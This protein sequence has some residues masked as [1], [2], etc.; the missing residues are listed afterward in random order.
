MA[1][2]GWMDRWI[3][4]DREMEEVK[5]EKQNDGETGYNILVVVTA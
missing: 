4:R 2:F 1:A 5:E 3:D